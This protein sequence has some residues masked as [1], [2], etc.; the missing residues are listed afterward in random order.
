ML[1]QGIGKGSISRLA[2]I[3]VLREELDKGVCASDEMRNQ[4][5]GA[6]L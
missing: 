4:G 1:I 6:V 5:E 3:Y 2:A